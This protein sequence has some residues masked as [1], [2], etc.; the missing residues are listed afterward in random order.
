MDRQWRKTDLVSSHCWLNQSPTSPT[1]RIA[2][3]HFGK[4]TT[5]CWSLNSSQ[6]QSP[7]W[8]HCSS[9]PRP[10]SM[11]CQCEAVMREDGDPAYLYPEGEGWP[12]RHSWYLDTN[13][14]WGGGVATANARTPVASIGSIWLQSEEGDCWHGNPTVQRPQV[15]VAR[16]WGRTHRHVGPTQQRHWGKSVFASAH[17][18]GHARGA[19]DHKGPYVGSRGRLDGLC[20]MQ[21]WAGGG[22]TVIGLGTNSAQNGFY[23]FL[24]SVFLFLFWF[25]VSNLQI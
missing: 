16:T 6:P 24:F 13:F 8:W 5:P 19:A 12:R 9:F 25:Q 22:L 2:S 7:P 14:F 10:P 18:W 17:R 15:R 20:G 11:W 4:T 23:S 21:Y 3:S 1:P